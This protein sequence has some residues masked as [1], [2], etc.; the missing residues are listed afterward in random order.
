[1]N[2]EQYENR[3]QELEERIEELEKSKQKSGFRVFLRNSFFMGCIFDKTQTG[4]MGSYI[5]DDMWIFKAFVFLFGLFL[6]PITLILYLIG[7]I[8]K[9]IMEGEC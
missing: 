8:A 5:G 2:K 9:W 6:Y 1:M 3:I 7:F 4:F